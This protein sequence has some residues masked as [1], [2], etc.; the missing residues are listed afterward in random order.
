MT[1]T[2]I[3]T[4]Q[5]YDVHYDPLEVIGIITDAGVEESV[6]SSTTSGKDDVQYA[7]IEQEIAVVVSRYSPDT[8][9][10][11]LWYIPDYIDQG[12]SVEMAMKGLP[13]KGIKLHPRAHHWDFADT[14][15]LDTLHE[16]F[17]YASQHKLPVLI[18]TGYDAQDEA[19]RFSSFFD[20]YPAARCILAHCRPLDQTIKLLA[21]YPNVY[22][23]TAF[24][25]E[26][27]LRFIMK[28]GFAS[29]VLLGSDF[30][31]TH[32]FRSKYPPNG[33]GDTPTLTEQYAADL[34]QLRRYS[35]IIQT[36]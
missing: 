21:A 22:C 3:H 16:L 34:K 6:F 32:Y 26:A 31:I 9:K 10:P 7:E 11:F 35:G 27:D 4:G 28:A 25:E 12:I 8:I 30:P 13:Y 14:R 19:N 36:V 5:F 1:D 2:H 23:D 17:E 15:A 20:E 24:V 18:H 33:S 29:R